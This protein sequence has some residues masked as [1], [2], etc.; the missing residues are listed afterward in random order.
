MLPSVGVAAP[1]DGAV[2]RRMCGCGQESDEAKAER[3]GSLDH[4]CILTHSGAA[5]VTVTATM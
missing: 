2:A 4:G 5:Y 3:A 1:K